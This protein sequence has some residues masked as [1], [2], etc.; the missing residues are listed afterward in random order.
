[1]L[2]IFCRVSF[3]MICNEE[4]IKFEDSFG[5]Y[6]LFEVGLIVWFCDLEMF[7]LDNDFV[8]CLKLGI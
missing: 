7:L 3:M 2:W 8:C 6:W 5:D 1:M 4:F